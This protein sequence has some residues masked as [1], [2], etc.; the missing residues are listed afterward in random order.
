MSH[1]KITV[2]GQGPDSAGV[3]T[4]AV[5]DLSDVSAGTPAGGEA[6]IYEAASSSWVAGAV[7]GA[8]GVI[9]IGQGE[10]N[11]YSNSGASSIGANTDIYLYDTSPSNNIPS[12]T[13]TKYLSTDWVQSVT[14]PA[15]DYIVWARYAVEFSATGYLSFA[16]FDSSNTQLGARAVI[17]ED[18]TTYAFAPGLVQ[19][20]ILLTASTTIKLRAEAVS[21]VD[22]VANQGNTPA[23]FGQLTIVKVY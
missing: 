8:G 13:I 10:A 6:L 17:G 5:S 23:E 12:A 7:A 15:G 20:R 19:T 2:N 14:L 1:N 16:L 18:T 9:N 3:I 4:Q 11:A 21:G 22:T